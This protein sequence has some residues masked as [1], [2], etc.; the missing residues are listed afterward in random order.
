MKVANPLRL[1]AVSILGVTR[2]PAPSEPNKEL[3][4]HGHYADFIEAQDIDI[5]AEMACEKAREKM[6]DQDGWELVHVVVDPI[7]SAFIRQALQLV[8]MGLLVGDEPS[9]QRVERRCGGSRADEYGR[10]LFAFDKPPS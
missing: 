5:A 8:Q 3:V 9:E 10:I 2:F 7:S 6:T 4:A 1:Y